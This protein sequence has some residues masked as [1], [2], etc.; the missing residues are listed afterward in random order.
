MKDHLA[1]GHSNGLVRQKALD[2]KQDHIQ[3]IELYRCLRCQICDVSIVTHTNKQIGKSASKK[4]AEESRRREK[5]SVFKGISSMICYPEIGNYW[6]IHPLYFPGA[7]THVQMFKWLAVR[8][9]K[10]RYLF[11]ELQQLQGFLGKY[12]IDSTRTSLIILRIHF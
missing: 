12:L 11:R 2:R 9:R 6:P 7:A 10:M 3:R 1:R 5:Q 4:N 8:Q